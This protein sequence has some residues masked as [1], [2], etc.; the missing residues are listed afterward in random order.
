MAGKVSESPLFLVLVAVL[1]PLVG[2]TA[3]GLVSYGALKASVDRQNSDI[4]K[5]IDTARTMPDRF[6]PRREFEAR[7]DG[8][9]QRL[10]TLQELVQAS[11]P[12]NE[13]ALKLLES[14]NEA[15]EAQLEMTRERER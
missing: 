9:D 7:L 11:G 15:A 13:A 5:L 14:L 3:G 1:G 10:E 6:L 12:R 4:D 2:A 8:L